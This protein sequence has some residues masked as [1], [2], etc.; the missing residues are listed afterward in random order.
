MS[1]IIQIRLYLGMVFPTKQSVHNDSFITTVFAVTSNHQGL[2][3]TL[4]TREGSTTSTISAGPS[5]FI[6]P[7]SESASA[8]IDIAFASG[9]ATTIALLTRCEML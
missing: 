6:I 9:R 8:V 2:M 5:M 1:F 4:R 3:T 7:F